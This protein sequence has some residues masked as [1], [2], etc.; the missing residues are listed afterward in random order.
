MPLPLETAQA[1]Y[2]KKSQY[3][4]YI[5]T[6]QWDKFS[7]VALPNAKLSFHNRDGSVLKAGKRHLTFSSSQ[8]FTM[9]F[10]K[11]FA[12][13]QSLHIFGPGD[14]EQTADDEVTAI[15][16]MEDQIILKG[17]AGLVEMR[18]GGYYFE[19]WKKVGDDWFLASLGLER[20]YQKISFLGRFI[21]FLETCLGVS[22][23]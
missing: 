22:F 8:E 1:V 13:A 15:W 7:E 9:F 11:F 18:G 17:S 21:M 2:R 14:L 16:G 19:T 12:N 23:V 4:R 20:T 10:S 3:G 6:K 5:D